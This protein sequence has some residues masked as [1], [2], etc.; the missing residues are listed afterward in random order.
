[1][2]SVDGAMSHPLLDKI[3]QGQATVAVIGMGYVGLPLAVAF[4]EAGFPVVGIE[5]DPRRVAALQ[6]GESYVEDIPSRRLVECMQAGRLAVSADPL[7]LAS[8][9]VV[10]VCVQTPVSPN[11]EPDLS[12][13]LRAG[14]A[15]ARHLHPGMLV[16]LESTTYPGTTEE[17]LLPL[18][19]RGGLRVG[20]DFFLAY[21]PERIDP[22]NRQWTVQ[23]TPKV[24]GGITPFCR[25]IACALYQRVTTQVVPVASATTA[26][27]VKLLE[28]TFRAVNIALINDIALLCERLGVD[29]W[30]VI[31][32]AKT[33]PFG[34]MPFYPG[35]GV[36]GHCIPKDFRILDW[37]AQRLGYASRLL[38]ETHRINAGMPGVVVEKVAHALA[39][40]GRSLAG[41][42]VLVLGVAYKPDVADT[43]DSP[44]LEVMRLLRER[45]AE[46]SFHDPHVPTLHLDGAVLERVPL[47]A[48]LARA[49]CVVIITAHSAYDW[50]WVVTRSRLVVDTRNATAGIKGQDAIVVR[51]GVGERRR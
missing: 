41:A 25:E 19:E 36:G 47:E 29:V 34:F 7:P 49:D 31:D 6:R 45:G 8:V 40:Q 2:R 4:A 30:E 24:V 23:N 12:A 5:Q 35:P 11:G 26:E 22:G 27:M 17:V 39:R 37:R 13:I 32:A 50:P 46:V 9:D 1:M 15:I 16:V 48:G 43:R 14:D 28:N 3:N 20:H 51:L 42:Q 33:K 21:S 10:I 44:A 18:L 38:A